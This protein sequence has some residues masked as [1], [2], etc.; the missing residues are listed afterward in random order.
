MIE[1]IKRDRFIQVMLVI[2]ALLVLFICV[3]F[4]LA[5][6]KL[7]DQINRAA[8]AQLPLSPTGSAPINKPAPT[9]APP[10]AAPTP[11]PQLTVDKQEFQGEGNKVENFTIYRTGLVYFSL[12]HRSTRQTKPFFVVLKSANGETL[13][14]LLAAQGNSENEVAENLPA[15]D[16]ILEISGEIWVIAVLH[17]K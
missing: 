11:E 16:Y 2:A 15:G 4:G 8:P 13:K 17:N 9:V 12:V 3:I 6:G 5:A 14:Y 7:L 10:A 1:K